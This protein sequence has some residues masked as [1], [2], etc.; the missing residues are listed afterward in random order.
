MKTSSSRA[1]SRSKKKRKEI[2]RASLRDD[3]SV[4]AAHGVE[5]ES[6]DHLRTRRNVAIALC[7]PLFTGAVS[8]GAGE[9]GEQHSFGM[10]GRVRASS[11]QNRHVA[12]AAGGDHP[13][14]E[15]DRIGTSAEPL[16]CVTDFYIGSYR[17]FPPFA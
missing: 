6:S 10:R 16:H 5:L 11:R 1:L 2:T 14:G 8:S 9:L 13:S 4:F 17:P 7:A 12:S 3:R 15:G